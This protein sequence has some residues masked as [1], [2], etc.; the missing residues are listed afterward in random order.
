MQKRLL[1]AGIAISSSLI[2]LDAKAASFSGS[3]FSGL[4]IFGDSTV[5][6]GNLFNLTS[7]FASL[8]VPALPP[9]PP[10]A[11][12]SSNGPIWIEIVQ[13][14]L[15]LSPTLITDFLTDLARDPDTPP[16]TQGINFAFTGSLSSDIHVADD[17]I[18]PLA[19]LLPGFQEQIETFTALSAAIP[20]DPEALYVVSVGGNDYNEAFFAPESL[21]GLT[22]DELPN[23][24]TD[25]IVDGLK[26]LNNLGAQNFFVF[27]QPPLG[28]TPFADF[29]DAQAQQDI[30]SL[31]NQLTDTHNILLSEKLSA[32]GQSQPDVNIIPFNFN[33]LLLD[34]ID[35]PQSFGLKNVTES[36]LINFRPGIQFD[37]VCDN[38]EDFFFWD[39]VHPTEAAHKIIG[40]SALNALSVPEPGSPAVLL[41]LGLVG[42]GIVQKRRLTA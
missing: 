25:N 40:K 10:Y 14:A 15:G 32:F 23:A 9:S 1:A 24:V 5:D 31:L 42:A 13:D 39:D 36:C 38:P 27:N 8:G 18:P 4:N 22:L 37:G 2:P 41:A 3:P 11:Q 28:E 30:S 33:A 12:K 6:T 17:N 19:P 21:R 35:K 20:T 26:Q 16:P 7:S 29:L 34:I